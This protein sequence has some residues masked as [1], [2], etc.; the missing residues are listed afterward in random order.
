MVKFWLLTILHWNVLN[1]VYG[2]VLYKSYS[3]PYHI[4][5]SFVAVYQSIAYKS[6]RIYRF[7]YHILHNW[8]KEHAVHYKRIKYSGL[9]MVKTELIK[10]YIYIRLATFC[11][12]K[13]EIINQG[14]VSAK[15]GSRLP[16]FLLK[17]LFLSIVGEILSLK[18]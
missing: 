1:S 15:K 8:Y 12:E 10:Q 13:M 3:I 14:P 11:I 18:Q 6:H 7:I 17:F 2:G 16:Y 9:K 4:I 5:K